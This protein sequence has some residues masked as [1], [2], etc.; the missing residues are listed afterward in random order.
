MTYEEYELVYKKYHKS[1]Y[2]IGILFFKN[3]HD[4]YDVTADV[5]KR[6][7]EKREEI[8]METIQ[9]YLNRITGNWCIDLLRT[10]KLY[11]PIENY[12][13]LNDESPTI[14]E[15]MEIAHIFSLIVSLPPCQKNI[16]KLQY[17]D[18]YSPTDIAKHLNL[19]YQTVRNTTYQA[20]IN[21]RKR[22]KKRG[23]IYHG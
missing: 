10:R 6:V 5:F 12:H 11:H 13:W 16:I 15:N 14:L 3:K 20:L 17:F 23:I 4:A 18:G 22:I 19:S 8:R 1:V 9:Q 2:N 21:L 7:W